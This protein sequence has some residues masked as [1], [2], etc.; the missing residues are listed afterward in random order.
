MISSIRS[1][2]FR[3][4]DIADGTVRIATQCLFTFRFAGHKWAQI[5]SRNHDLNE[6]DAKTI[7]S[8]LRTTALYYAVYD[9]S[10][11][12]SYAL[13]HKGD[14]IER[15]EVTYPD[16]SI[17]ESDY[18]SDYDGDYDVDWYSAVEGSR[19]DVEVAAIASDEAGPEDDAMC[20]MEWVENLFE[21]LDAYESGITFAHL[22]GAMTHKPGDT[23]VVNDQLGEIER[24]DYIDL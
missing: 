5:V 8:R 11:A 7:S 21:R 23:F 13:F 16:D 22:I 9:T 14:L 20:P 4:T 3:K 15:L 17:E 12:I 10:F 1:A 2:S 24:V 6:D 19:L 18:D